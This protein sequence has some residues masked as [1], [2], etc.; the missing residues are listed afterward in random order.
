MKPVDIVVLILVICVGFV[1]TMPLFNFVFTGTH[2]SAESSKLIGGLVASMIAIV[3]I[4]VGAKL[5]DKD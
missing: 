3:S 1:V 5:K 2:N 4:Y